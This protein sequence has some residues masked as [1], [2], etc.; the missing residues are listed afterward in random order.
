MPFRVIQ[1]HI[2][3]GLWKDDKGLKHY[4]I[5][6]ASFPKVPKTSSESPKIHVFDYPLLF[7][8]PHQGTPA[9]IRIDLILPES[10][11]I[12]LHLR[13]WQ[14]GSIFIQI[15]VVASEIR[16]CFETECVVALHG[17]PRS[18]ILAPIESAYATSYWSSI[19]TLVLSCPVSEILQV[20]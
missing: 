20:S 6:L 1:S 8:A 11:V 15:F 2:F 10:G 17:H 16:M 3:W 18:L 12:G 5:T 19:V 14:I 13:R 4:I 7:D 9:N